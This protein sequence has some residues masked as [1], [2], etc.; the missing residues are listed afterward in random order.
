[1]MVG[2]QRVRLLDPHKRLTDLAVGS[3][4]VDGP[5]QVVPLSPN[6]ETEH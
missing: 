6:E 3:R 4:R 5:P 2:G 1:V